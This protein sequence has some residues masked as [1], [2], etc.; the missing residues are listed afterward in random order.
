MKLRGILLEPTKA[1]EKVEIEFNDYRDIS[2][3]VGCKWITAVPRRFNGVVAD[4]YCD[5]EYLL[6]QAR[7]PAIITRNKTTRATIEI[8]YGTCFLCTHDKHGNVQSM[9]HTAIK[10][11]LET[12][13]S[14]TQ[15]ATTFK[16]LQ[17]EM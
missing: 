10:K 12:V 9:S 2:K 8:L 13:G 14:V 17:A 11:I 16:V 3:A 5:E 4:V 7:T 1:I 15:G 6:K